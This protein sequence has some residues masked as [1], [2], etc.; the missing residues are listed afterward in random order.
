MDRTNTFNLSTTTTPPRKIRL[1]GNGKKLWDVLKD[2]KDQYA[3]DIVHTT[4]EELMDAA[5][6]NKRSLYDA[7]SELEDENLAKIKDISPEDTAVHYKIKV[8]GDGK[9]VS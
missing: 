2:L 3:S 7:F 4:E 6:M 9:A 1:S 8:K 5:D